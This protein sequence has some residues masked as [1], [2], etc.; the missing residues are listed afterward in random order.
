MPLIDLVIVKILKTLRL[1]YN[2]T[3]RGSELPI[4]RPQ[5]FPVVR[6]NLMPTLNETDSR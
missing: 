1:A 4:K 6:C 2:A 3:L 5:E